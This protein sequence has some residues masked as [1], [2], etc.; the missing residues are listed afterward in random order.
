MCVCVFELMSE[1]LSSYEGHSN[2]VETI[3]TERTCRPTIHD[4]FFD[5]VPPSQH[6]L[7]RPLKSPFPHH[8]PRRFICGVHGP[9]N[10]WTATSALSNLVPRI[11][12]LTCW[13]R[14]YSHGERY[15]EQ[16]GLEISCTSV[17]A[18]K[19]VIA[20]AAGCAHGVIVVQHESTKT[21]LLAALASGL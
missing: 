16:G 21:S 5:E 6:T 11:C 17:M 18:R 10:S 14:N 9:V 4:N 13:N 12:F 2:N 19:S 7:C 8:N 20:A 15:G 1:S 3:L